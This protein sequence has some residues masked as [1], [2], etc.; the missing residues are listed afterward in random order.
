MSTTTVPGLAAAY[1]SAAAT[2]AS[3]LPLL[4]RWKSAMSL[5]G[6]VVYPV[7]RGTG[8]IPTVVDF[9]D[10]TSM[11]LREQL[12]HSGRLEAPVRLWRYLAARRLE[13]ELLR[14]TPHVAFIS[15]RDRAAVLG[16]ES[17]AAVIPNGIDLEYWTRR[18]A[19]V[20]GER[21]VFTGVMGYAPNADAA[22]YLIERILPVI[23]ARRPAVELFVVGRDPTPAVVEAALRT[24][25][26]TV[27]G[28]VDDVR[29]YLE[30]ARVYVAPLRWASGLQNKILEAIGFPTSMFTAIF[31]LS[32][33]V[34]WI[35]QWKEMIA[36]PQKK[37]GRPRQLYHGSA[38]R[39][40]VPIGNR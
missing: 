24:K 14:E 26:V 22:L 21:I 11:R 34:G 37:I 4:T 12:R 3:L 36:D 33:T 9:C 27:T 15:E 31:A 40:Y 28:W 29:P 8:R 1:A 7:I 25:G 17:T 23:R 18:D 13:R 35:A 5:F 10:A 32:R 20:V 2:A 6:K 19:A 38:S 16:P 39:D 30:Q